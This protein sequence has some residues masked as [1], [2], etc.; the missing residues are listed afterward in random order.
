M[1]KLARDRAEDPA[2]LNNRLKLADHLSMATQIAAGSVDASDLIDQLADAVIT[3]DCVG[4]VTSFNRAAEELL[5]YL[6]AEILGRNVDALVPDELL[7]QA[8]AE[9]ALVLGGETRRLHGHLR[10]KDSSVCGVSMTLSPLRDVTGEIV[11]TVCVAS[12]ASARMFREQQLE[13]MSRLISETENVAMICTDRGGRVTIFNRGAE[14]L[15]G[16]KQAEVLG[17][18]AADLHDAED[19]S[20]RAAAR[21]VEPSASFFPR[22]LAGEREAGVWTLVRKDGSRVDVLL[23]ARAA[24][25]RFGQAQG[26]IAMA[27]DIARMPDP[28]LE[29]LQAEER[30]RVAFEHAP[31]GL[32]IT[33]LEGPDAGCW[34]QTNPALA[35][36]LGWQ[37]GELDGFAINDATHP[38]DRR[39]TPGF[40]EQLRNQQPIVVEKRFLRRDGSEVWAYVSSTPVPSIDGGSASSSV[41]QVLDISERRHFEQQLRHLA[42]HDPLTELYNRR[43][44]ELELE[45]AILQA[46]ASGYTLALIVLDLDGFKLVNDRFG[47]AVGDELVTHISGLLRQ[48]VRDRDFVARLG[49]DE[50]AIILR[51]CD[52]GQAV[53]LAERVLA[54]IRRHG[55]VSTATAPARTTTSVGIALF[56]PGCNATADE[57]A[58]A[59]DSAMYDAKAEGR[60]RCVVYQPEGMRPGAAPER[61]SWFSRIRRALEEER[62]VLHAQPIVPICSAGLPRFELLVRMIA[63]NGAIV[64]PGAFLLNAERFDLMGELDRWVLR[65]AVSL[66]HQQAAEGRDLSLSVNLSGKTMNDLTLVDDLAELLREHPIPPGRLVVEV[67]E[68]AAIVNIQR[69]RELAR[70]LRQLGCLFALDDFGSGFSSFYY[71]KHL[72]FD[73]LKID[74]EFIVNL[75]KSAT[76]QLLVKAVVDIAR[77]IGTQTVAEFVGDDC[78]VELLRQYG[79]DYGQGY[80]LGRPAPVEEI[81]AGLPS[82]AQR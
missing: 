3:T 16:Y 64:P 37:P 53:E 5:G 81:L 31:I 1:E 11:G 49:G 44:F 41:T 55:F 15:L 19:V 34:R 7:Q 76:D 47:H 73:Y 35:R 70:Q 29:R 50:F 4:Q 52:R 58:I 71:L 77:G 23:T 32:A 26:I 51:N 57:L 67:T 74:G 54:T 61:D 59:A 14:E 46:S 78:T 65:R 62:F 13:F 10:N 43:R 40:I 60:D 22:A 69:A 82:T 25:D 12:D 42:D 38:D 27:R 45:R 39:L 79:V 28:E 17:T 18:Q 56:E 20:R 21:G 72:E 75:V 33:S 30:F 68:T 66:L 36:M 48:S 9:R 8:H 63:D 6:S 2:H 24:F 80:H